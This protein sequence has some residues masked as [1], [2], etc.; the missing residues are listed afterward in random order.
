MLRSL[1]IITHIYSM[2]AGEKTSR[3]WSP[4]SVPRGLVAFRNENITNCF[5]HWLPLILYWTFLV[6][7]LCDV[8]CSSLYKEGVIFFT[9]GNRVHPKIRMTKECNGNSMI[10]V[11]WCSPLTFCSALPL[12]DLFISVTYRNRMA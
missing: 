9:K 5:P 10:N 7:T 11:K 8:T 1:K 6:K 12:K 2:S 3:N 4:I